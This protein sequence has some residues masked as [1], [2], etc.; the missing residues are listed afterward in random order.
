MNELEAIDLPARNRSRQIFN[1][2]DFDMHVLE[3]GYEDPNRPSVLLL[4]GFP[5]LAYSWG[6][7]LLGLAQD[8]LAWPAMQYKA[9]TST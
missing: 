7:T 9:S 2:N 1:V 5:G 4:H 3:A 8:G 6:K